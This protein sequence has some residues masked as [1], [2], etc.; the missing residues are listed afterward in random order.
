MKQACDHTRLD[1]IVCIVDG[2]W[3]PDGYRYPRCV[4]CGHRVSYAGDQP[5][6]TRHIMRRHPLY[7]FTELANRRE[8]RKH[9]GL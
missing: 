6:S 1:M 3:Q 8:A 5:M 9:G 4:R 7:L 2:D